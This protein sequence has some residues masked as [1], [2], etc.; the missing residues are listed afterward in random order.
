MGAVSL[1][2]SNRDRTTL[3][4]SAALD[5]KRRISG[6]NED[7][8]IAERIGNCP[9]ILQTGKFSCLALFNNLT[10]IDQSIWILQYSIFEV[11]EGYYSIK[12]R[13]LSPH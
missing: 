1:I 5:I 13:T 4:K 8:C 12:P 11:R 6:H 2:K 3:V 10:I 7:K 9:I